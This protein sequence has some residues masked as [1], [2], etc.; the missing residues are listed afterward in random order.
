M[1]ILGSQVKDFQ[2]LL[3]RKQTFVALCLEM[4]IIVTNRFKQSQVK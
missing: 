2:G 4:G 3:T 1:R